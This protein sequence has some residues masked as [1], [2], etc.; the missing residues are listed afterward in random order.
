MI[1]LIEAQIAHIPVIRRIALETWPATF[2]GILSKEQ[3]AYM[4]DMMYSEASLAHQ[5]TELRHRFVLAQDTVDDQYLGYLSYERPY[6]DQ[7]QTKIHKIYVLPQTQGQGV[8]KQLME[9][10]EL[11]ARQQGDHYLLLNVNKHNKAEAFYQRLGFETI[12]TEDIDIGNGYL[13]ED[14]IMRKRLCR[15]D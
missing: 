13:M 1:Q 7:P 14:K 2:G 10:A 12:G 8:G 11:A 6:L 5:V 4:L 9:A 15:V 3:I